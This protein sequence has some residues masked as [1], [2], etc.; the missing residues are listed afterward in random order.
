MPRLPR[1]ERPH[2]CVPRPGPPPAGFPSSS[3]CARRRDGVPAG[4]DALSADEPIGRL[5]TPDEIAAAVRR[6]CPDAASC[7]TGQA[8]VVDG[9]RTV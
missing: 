7:A 3:G 5:G 6:L 1:K 4:R 2:V 9:G 8:L